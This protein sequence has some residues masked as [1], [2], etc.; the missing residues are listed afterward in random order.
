MKTHLRRA[1]YVFNNMSLDI[2]FLIDA[3]GSM[4]AVIN[5]V[6]DHIKDLVAKLLVQHTNEVRLGVVA[7]RDYNDFPRI[8]KLPFTSNVQDF[9]NFLQRLEAKGGQDE[10]EDVFSGLYEVTHMEWQSNARLLAHFA[11]APCHGQRYHS[12]SSDNWKQGD[13]D[14]RD[15]GEILKML[16][17][18]CN[19]HSYQFYHLN[20]TTKQMLSEFKKDFERNDWYQED[21]LDN[22]A[23]MG[24]LMYH[25]SIRSIEA[26]VAIPH[27]L[28]L[29]HPK[30]AR[31][32]I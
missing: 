12:I 25:S 2:C 16:A 18:E 31:I 24:N 19:I 32:S 8:D 4:G 14:G 21:Q 1:R 3:T 9:T 23:D 20:N 17:E 28:S 7:Y 30:K 26:S 11:D 6:K 5:G 13:R 29:P 22:I 10:A 27:S 15:V